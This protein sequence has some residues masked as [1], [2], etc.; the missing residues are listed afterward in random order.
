[1]YFNWIYVFLTAFSAVL[2]QIG[3][4]NIDPAFILLIGSILAVFYF[5]LINYSKIK[6][7]YQHCFKYRKNWFYLSLIVAVMW[8]TS[9]Y[10]PSLIGASLHTTIYFSVLGIC[11]TA[12]LY[13][14]KNQKNISGLVGLFG[15]CGILIYMVV[16][17]ILI[18]RNHFEIFG[19]MLPVLGGVSGFLYA[20]QSANFMSLSGLSATQVLAVRFYLTIIF[21]FFLL[22]GHSLISLNAYSFL[23]S[24]SIGAFCLIIPLYFTQKGIEKSGPEVSAIIV[25]TSPFFTSVFEE[26]YFKNL[27]WETFFISGLYAFFAVL[28]FIVRWMKTGLSSKFASYS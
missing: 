8:I 17:S 1:M 10:A 26:A 19:I 15:L 12:W 18:H 11:G 5:H 28:P 24:A 27:T 13:F 6:S 3:G 22:P 9:I 16:R 4:R 7:I 23:M 21:C 20:K 2:R 25:S 14:Q